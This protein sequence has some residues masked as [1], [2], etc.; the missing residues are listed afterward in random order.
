V[1]CS[2]SKPGEYWRL[3]CS[4]YGLKRAPKFW[5]EKLLAHLRGVGLQQSQI[6]PCIFMGTLLKG[7]P[8]IYVSIYVDDVIYFSTDDTVEREFE[9][10]LGTIGNL[11]FIGQVSHFL[12]IEFSWKHHDDGNGNLSVTLTPQS[13]AENLVD[14]VNYS[15]ASVSG[16]IS[17]YR[18]GLPIDSIPIL[19]LSTSDQDKLHL[20][21]Q[22]LV[23]SLNWLAHTTRLDL[24]TVVSLLAQH[25]SNASPGHLDAALHVI[26][27]VAQ[28]KTM[29]IHFSS[30]KRST[31]ESFLHFPLPLVLLS[32][33]YANWGPQDASISS[34]SKPM[35]LPLFASRSMSAFYVDLLGP[36]HW[37]SKCQT[38]TA[39]S[40]AEAEIYA[41]NE[42][43]KFLLK[44]VQLLDFLG[45]RELFMPG[46]MVIYN[47]N[48]A[49][50]NWSKSSTSKGL[51]HIQMKENHV[52]ENIAN[53]FV[54]IQHIEG[55]INL[56]DLFT[57]QMKDTAHFIELRDLLVCHQYQT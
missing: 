8:P 55:R 46:T 49:C 47:D 43:V 22:S 39:G 1:G 51:R 18:S 31:L 53:N 14:S 44:L 21:Y 11:D 15:I 29:G 30:C 56:A 5:F 4:L 10:Q 33:S 42:C 48:Q 50:V 37:M 12:V 26:K 36:L 19:Q 38:V 7:H 32:M 27:Y 52:R 54:A 6:S 35:E 24:P 9:K 41:T 16:Y 25:Q 17:P 57:K 2:R 23:G 34:S 13:F 28:T 45:V 3:L 20:Q 40:T